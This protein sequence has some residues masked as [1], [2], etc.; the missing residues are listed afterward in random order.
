MSLLATTPT[1]K[2][3]TPV[4]STKRKRATVEDPVDSGIAAVG[5]LRGD[6]PG[7]PTDVVRKE[8]KEAFGEDHTWYGGNFLASLTTV[9]GR[10]LTVDFVHLWLVFGTAFEHNY[11]FGP[12]NAYNA[13][14]PHLVADFIVEQMGVR[15]EQIER[16]PSGGKTLRYLVTFEEGQIAKLTWKFPRGWIKLARGLGCRLACPTDHSVSLL[17]ATI[18]HV[19]A[20]LGTMAIQRSLKMEPFIKDVVDFTRVVMDNGVKTDKIDV[21]VETVEGTDAPVS[22]KLE[23]FSFGFTVKGCRLELSR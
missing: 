17:R 22:K 21:L 19:P 7:P 15:P 12:K 2:T 4:A 1:T 6:A 5:G 13:R 23:A 9:E 8:M 18:A 14:S 16:F 3:K 11:H 20:G 10:A